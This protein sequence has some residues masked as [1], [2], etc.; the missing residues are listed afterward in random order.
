M[1]SNKIVRLQKI[2]EEGS[3]EIYLNNFIV[4]E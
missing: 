1:V 3:R 2:D 4:W